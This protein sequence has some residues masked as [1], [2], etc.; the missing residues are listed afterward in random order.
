[1]KRKTH[2]FIRRAHRYLGLFLGLQFLLWTAGGLYFS[3]SD[4]DEIHGDHHRKAP[5]NFRADMPLVSPSQI[6]SH[7]PRI[8]SVKSIRLI[9]IIGQPIYQIQYFSSAAGKAV[10]K[11]QL[12][13]AATGQLRP[14][15]TRQEAIALATSDFTERVRVAQVE[16]LTEGEVNGHHEYRESPLPAWAVTVEHPTQTTVYVTA[17]QGQV[18]KFRNNR[19]R[20]FDFLWMLHTMDYQGRDNIGNVLLRIFSIAGM[21]TILSGFALYFVS[22]GTKR[23]VGKKVRLSPPG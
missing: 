15:I 11:T 12:A 4:M 2:L 14:A 7:L 6:I 9:E 23:A 18:T 17:E 16:Y 3:W 8:D 13:V 20:I 1:M 22:S 5:L 21:V 19:W 10:V